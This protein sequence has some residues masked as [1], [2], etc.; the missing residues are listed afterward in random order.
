MYVYK[1]CQSIT[2][3]AL[4]FITLNLLFALSGVVGRARELKIVVD[5]FLFMR[6]QFGG[7]AG[8]LLQRP[9]V[10][11]SISDLQKQMCGTCK[12]R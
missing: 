6:R 1:T 3:A 7:E 9:L 8:F 10:G 11:E 12:I 2:Y 4:G 5:D